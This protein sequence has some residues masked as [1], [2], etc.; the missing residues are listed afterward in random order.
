MNRN[1]TP[2]PVKATGAKEAHGSILDDA[3]GALYVHMH[4]E[5]GLAHRH[6]V[7]KPW[8]VRVLAA[9]VSRPATILY[10]MALVMWGWMAVQ[11]TRVELLQRRV[12]ELTRDAARLDTLTLQLD[13]MQERYD[14]VQKM[15]RAAR[16]QGAAPDTRAVS[17][18]P[19]PAPT[20]NVQ[21]APADTGRD[22]L[23]DTMPTITR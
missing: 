16:G 14:Q 6:Y 4:R 23:P 13:R 19:T 10:V 3:S 2:R 7:F 22:T 20:A 15:L 17:P 21:K 18:R 12:G 5:S 8:Q 11:A 9:L 1:L